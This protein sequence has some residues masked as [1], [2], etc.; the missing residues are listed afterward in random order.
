MV[1]CSG[2][3]GQYCSTVGNRV[4]KFSV[5]ALIPALFKRSLI[6]CK[7]AEC[8][9]LD[10]PMVSLECSECTSLPQG[11]PHVLGSSWT[12]RSSQRPRSGVTSPGFEE[13]VLGAKDV[14][15]P[16]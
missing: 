3:Q 4:I 2:N 10:C 16:A 7:Y 1:P 13:T 9:L 5:L 8:L 14:G 11:R 6:K 12:D 15:E